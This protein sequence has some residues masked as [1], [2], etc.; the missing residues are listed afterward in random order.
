MAI[1]IKSIQRRVVPGDAQSPQKFYASALTAGS[2]DFKKMS[3]RIANQCTVRPADCMAVLTALEENIITDLEDG[4]IVHMGDLGT[5][6]VSIS[7]GGRDTS[8]EVTSQDV[9]KARLLFRPGKGLSHMLKTLEY[10]KAE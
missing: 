5:L 2:T 7:S 9:K 3:K 4:V 10:K 6:R 1:R 8:D